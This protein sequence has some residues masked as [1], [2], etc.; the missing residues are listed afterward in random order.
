MVRV[1]EIAQNGR[2]TSRVE[3]PFQ[4]VFPEAARAAAAAS[5][6]TVQPGNTLW[7]LSVERYGEGL[8]YTVIFDANKDLIR[9][10]DLIYPGQSFSLPDQ[11]RSDQ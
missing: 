7:A 5:K 8:L 4:R 1:D 6:V 11:G 3:S 2:V 10:P 9:D